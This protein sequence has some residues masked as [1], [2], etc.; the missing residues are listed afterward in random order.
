MFWANG[1]AP[2]EKLSIISP[3]IMPARPQ[4]PPSP[5]A[6]PEKTKA[7][8]NIYVYCQLLSNFDVPTGSEAGRKPILYIRPR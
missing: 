7:L 6:G 2:R 5:V 1:Q 8:T 3:K 4:E